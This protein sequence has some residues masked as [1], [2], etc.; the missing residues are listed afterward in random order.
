MPDEPTYRVEDVI[1]GVQTLR[2]QPGDVVALLCP[3]RL[4]GE[5]R[6]RLAEQLRGAITQ[7]V[8]IIILEEGMTLARVTVEEPDGRTG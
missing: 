1:A 5:H 6:E 3:Y 2:F 8:K 4:S 7:D